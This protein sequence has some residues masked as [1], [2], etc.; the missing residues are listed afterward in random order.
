MKNLYIVIVLVINAFII[1]LPSSGISNNKAPGGWEPK[2][3]D[4]KIEGKAGTEGQCPGG[5]WT[6]CTLHCCKV[7]ET[8]K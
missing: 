2:E 3:V 8:P 6:S 1:F 4:C 7:Y 5:N